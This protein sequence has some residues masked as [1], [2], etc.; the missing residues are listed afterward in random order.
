MNTK[1][2]YRKNVATPYW[3]GMNFSA[4]KSKKIKYNYKKPAHTILVKKDLPKNVRVNT[5]RHE[6]A[7]GYLMRVKKLP[8][9]RAHKKALKF[10]KLEKPFPKKN[11]QRKLKSLGILKK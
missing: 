11:I 4:A 9:S 5:I 2:S 8:Y 1:I 3:Y 6:Q 7:E 10:E